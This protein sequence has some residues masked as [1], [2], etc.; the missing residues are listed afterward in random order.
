MESAATVSLKLFRW[1]AAIV[2]CL[3][4]LGSFGTVAFAVTQSAT[5]SVPGPTPEYSSW[6]QQV[7][8]LPLPSA[9]CFEATYP[10]VAWVSGGSNC[11]TPQPIPA[12]VGGG[13]SGSDWETSLSSGNIGESQ[14]YVSA[15]SGVTGEWDNGVPGANYYSLQDNS[16]TF[17]CNTP[18]TNNSNAEC[19]EQFLFFNDPGSSSGSLVIQYWLIGYLITHTSCPSTHTRL[20]SMGWQTSNPTS[21]C[22]ADSALSYTTPLENPSSLT[23]YQLK[24]YADLSGNDESVFCHT[25]TCYAVTVAHTVFDLSSYWT[26]AEWNVLGY[27]GS[28]ACFNPTSSP[29][30]CGPTGSPSVTV[31]QYLYNSGGTNIASN[32]YQNGTTGETNNLNV[33]SSCSSVTATPPD[34]YIYFTMT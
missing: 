4:L 1:S 15:M 27:S 33:P 12:T 10:T 6:Q 29:T 22:W 3:L 30:G 17:T 7:T 5:T 18:D 23:S 19:W 24:G 14:G 21:S 25:T 16:N 32:C 9:G 28:E 34:D 26:D 11:V 13:G 8:N 2:L 20:W 31:T